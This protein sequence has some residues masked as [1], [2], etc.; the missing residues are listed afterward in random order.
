M[1][2]GRAAARGAPLAGLLHWL[3]S[4]LAHDMAYRL[5]AEMRIDLYRKLDALA[6]AYLLRAALR[7]SGRAGDAGR[8]DGR[9]F[10]RP[11]GRAG[12]R[13]RAGP[14]RRAGGARV[15]RVAAGARAGAVPGLR[16][17]ARRCCGGG[18]STASASH[19]RAAPGRARRA[20]RP[21]RSRASPNWSRS[22]AGDAAARRVHGATRGATR[23]CGCALL[24]DLARQTA[25]PGGGNRP[26]RPGGRRGRR[27]AGAARL[28]RADARCRCWC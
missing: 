8:R 28:D 14:G 27:A 10:L 24:H 18:A 26:G 1:A 5:L 20:R 2:A 6:P 15:H 16:R 7:R 4:W 9:V 17:L 13:R 21:R 19:A 22:S 23:R 25:R 12:L 3:E 11:H